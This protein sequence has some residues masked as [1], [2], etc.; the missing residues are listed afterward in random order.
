MCVPPGVVEAFEAVFFNVCDRLESA[1]YIAH[2]A[3]G[4]G[5]QGGKGS[6][7]AAWKILGWSTKNPRL[8]E[9][10]ITGCRRGQ[11]GSDCTPDD[12]YAFAAEDMNLS[13]MIK[14][15]LATKMLPIND[16]TTGRLLAMQK[17][18][19]K[20]H[21]DEDGKDPYEEFA[22]N[23]RAAFGVVNFTVGQKM[24]FVGKGGEPRAHELLAAVTGGPKL[25][26]IKD[27]FEWPWAGCDAVGGAEVVADQGQRG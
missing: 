17:Q 14:S 5:L 9:E 22:E 7:K 18:L 11:I 23:M 19:V 25:S 2:Q 10:I 8:L 1:T 15:M 27:D 20:G 13:C 21:K 6:L 3:I 26:E 16:K 4:P 12:A 24:E